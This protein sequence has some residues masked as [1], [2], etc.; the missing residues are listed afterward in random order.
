MFHH[1]VPKQ[2]PFRVFQGQPVFLSLQAHKTSPALL[3]YFALFFLRVFCRRIRVERI[4]K[5]PWRPVRPSVRPRRTRANILRKSEDISMT[6]ARD[7]L[8]EDLQTF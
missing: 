5:C 7:I 4:M 8:S 6:I 2:W 3:T 1:D